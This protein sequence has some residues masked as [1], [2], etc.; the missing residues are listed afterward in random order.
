MDTKP[1]PLTKWREDNCYSR[2]AF[3]RLL[4]QKFPGMEVTGEAVRAWETGR[5]DPSL[6]KALAIEK[7]TDGA[8]KP[9]SFLRT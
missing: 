4:G 6:A 7:L 2:P 1:H 9:E 5:A 3:G 8:V